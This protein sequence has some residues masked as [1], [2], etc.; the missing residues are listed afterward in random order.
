MHSIFSSFAGERGYNNVDLS[1]CWCLF[2]YG[3]HGAVCRL[4]M[5]IDKSIM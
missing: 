3:S 1:E 5:S 4:H 2:F